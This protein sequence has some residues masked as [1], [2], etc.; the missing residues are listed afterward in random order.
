MP[1]A[2]GL[3]LNHG[4]DFEQTRRFAHLRQGSEFSACFQLAFEHEILD[5]V[6]NHAVFARGR[7]DD[8]PLG[9]RVRSFTCH[10]FDTR[11]VHDR[12]QFF[13]NRL[14]GRQETRTK[15]GCGNHGRTEGP[16][17][18]SDNV[19]HANTLAAACYRS[20]S[21]TNIVAG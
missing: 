13:R 12:Q 18:A 17:A 16:R 19:C 2:E 15:S 14:G 5:E 10:Q 3:L 11:C 1:E 20:V 9:S 7:H 6:G 21:T 4:V 8:E